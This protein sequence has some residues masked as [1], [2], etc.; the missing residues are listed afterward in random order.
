V[1]TGDVRSWSAAAR[2]VTPRPRPPRLGHLRPPTGHRRRRRSGAG[3]A[4]ADPL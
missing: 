3:P 4:A 1:T 2:D